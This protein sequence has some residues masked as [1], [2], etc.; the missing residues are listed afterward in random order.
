MMGHPLR[1][2]AGVQTTSGSPC[3]APGTRLQSHLWPGVTC[4]DDPHSFPHP[5]GPRAGSRCQLCLEGVRPGRPGWPPHLP[6]YLLLGGQH[7][8]TP[9]QLSQRS[10][11]W[12]KL[13]TA[14]P[15]NC[16]WQS[17]QHHLYPER[18]HVQCN[19]SIKHAL[20]QQ[21]RVL[22]PDYGH[23]LDLVRYMQP[24]QA[25]LG[26]FQEAVVLCTACPL[27]DKEIFTAF[28]LR[29]QTSI[30]M[31]SHATTQRINN[32]V[33]S[34]LF[35]SQQPLSTVP[36]ATVANGQP[37]LPYRG[38]SIII[39]ENH[40]KG[41]RI[42]KGKD[43][44]LAHGHGTMLVVEFPDNERTFIPPVTHA[45]DGEGDM[46]TYPFMLAYARTICKLQG[47]NLK[48]LLLWLD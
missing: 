12:R 14:P 8:E 11:G 2:H 3:D 22:D 13:P 48:H 1:H 32:I 17:A 29:A 46:T 16:R 18:W 31:A 5:G 21:F 6:S 10:G 43:A 40:N 23:F 9:Q 26:K 45:V 33:V 4:R 36:C 25:Q 35:H 42:V 20:Y 30:M 28:S 34:K 38:M 47:Q 44:S 37:I 19:N 7:S 24:T 15:L 39:T 27:E 41:C